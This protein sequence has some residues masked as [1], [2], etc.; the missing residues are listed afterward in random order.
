MESILEHSKVPLPASKI[1]NATNLHL[2]PCGIDHN[3]NANIPSYFFLVD[4]QY[5]S[6]QSQS[7]ATTIEV[8]RTST[9]TIAT[10][11][12]ST[13]AK[14]T[15]ENTITSSDAVSTLSSSPA[16]GLPESSFRGR[17]LKGT[18]IKVPNG[19][20][21]T[22]Y[23]SIE[24]TESKSPSNHASNNDMDMSIDM[25]D[26]DDDDEAYEAMLKGMQEQRKV[27]RVE[28]SFA[29]FTLWGHDQAPT[30]KND[31]LVK[32]MQWIDIANVLH[33]SV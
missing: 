25:G 17:T 1:Y 2:L 26:N 30:L 21:G 15:E 12:E 9:T 31:K 22:I 4:G 6:D 13:N 20:S 29:E 16:A 5:L 28:G 27:L 14:I 7:T 11:T 8:T 10:S 23:R 18:L 3:G 24:E 19:Y 32:A 33:A